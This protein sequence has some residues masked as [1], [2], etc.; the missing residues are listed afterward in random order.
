[1]LDTIEATIQ[2][3]LESLKYF[4]DYEEGCIFLI[5]TY[6]DLLLNVLT[7][8]KSVLGEKQNQT[9]LQEMENMLSPIH[10]YRQIPGYRFHFQVFCGHSAGHHYKLL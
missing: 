8:Q 4:E 6:E 1:L 2:G 3:M 5:N 10:K 7:S 9:I